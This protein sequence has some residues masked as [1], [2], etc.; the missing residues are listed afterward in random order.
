MAGNA[1]T[2]CDTCCY[3]S[4]SQLHCYVARLC[5][6][7][8]Q[9]AAAY[10]RLSRQLKSWLEVST[11]IYCALRMTEHKCL[12]TLAKDVDCWTGSYWT[13][14]E[15]MWQCLTSSDKIWQSLKS[16][17]HARHSPLQDMLDWTYIICFLWCSSTSSNAHGQ[18]RSALVYVAESADLTSL[19]RP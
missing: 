1:I 3:Q 16:T 17:S 8:M 6:A 5:A 18:S 14:D 2:V 7:V 15:C 4:N 11:Y 10:G 13:A 19:N 12:V 9:G